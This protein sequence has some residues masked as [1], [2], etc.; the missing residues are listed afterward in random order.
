MNLVIKVET[1]RNFHV[2]FQSA[3]SD[4]LKNGI[5]FEGNEQSGR[6]SGFGFEGSYTVHADSIEVRVEKK[7]FLVSEGRIKKEIEKYCNGL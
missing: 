3:K 4:A 2:A 7:P 6:A 1:P 5:V